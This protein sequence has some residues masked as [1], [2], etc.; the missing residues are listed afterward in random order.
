MGCGFEASRFK[1]RHI[2]AVFNPQDE[3]CA[4]ESRAADSSL[5]PAADDYEAAFVSAVLFFN[6]HSCSFIWFSYLLSEKCD[7]EKLQ[8]APNICESSVVPRLWCFICTKLCC[9]LVKFSHSFG[10][11]SMLGVQMIVSEVSVHCRSFCLISLSFTKTD[12][13]NN[14]L[15]KKKPV[16]IQSTPNWFLKCFKEFTGVEILD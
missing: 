1:S 5:Q 15:N 11:A 14:K 3:R 4:D 8:A 12:N 2:T 6:Q 7:R 16:N 9:W 10:F 13:K